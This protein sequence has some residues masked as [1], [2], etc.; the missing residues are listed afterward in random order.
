M[1]VD[2]GASSTMPVPDR[3]EVRAEPL[4]VLLSPGVVTHP[5]GSPGWQHWLRQTLAARARRAAQG[6]WELDC[7]AELAALC[8]RDPEF[9]PVGTMGRAWG[10]PQPRG[11]AR[12]W[13]NPETVVDVLLGSWHYSRAIRK[14]RAAALSLGGRAHERQG[15]WWAY[16]L[17]F[18]VY[19]AFLRACR[20]NTAVWLRQH[21]IT[22]AWLWRGELAP[23]P[24][25]PGPVTVEL[26]PLT[27]WS[28]VAMYAWHFARWDRVG[29]AHGGRLLLARV[30]V[31]RIFSVGGAGVGQPHVAEV[32]VDGLVGPISAYAWSIPGPELGLAEPL[33]GELEALL[34]GPT[35]QPWPTLAARFD[36]LAARYDPRTPTRPWRPL[37]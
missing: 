26:D 19:R 8:Q 13:T 14:F 32:I 2:A 34:L 6:R 5:Y 30:P 9:R 4:R 28:P 7:I 20:A 18:G 3:A 31:A 12:V 15:A 23:G 17:S 16:D 22:D 21:G 1:S 27:F 37:G 33:D 24:E 35:S 36:P 10:S 25:Q 11:S 29:R